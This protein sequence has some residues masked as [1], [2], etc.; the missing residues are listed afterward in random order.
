MSELEEHV[1]DQ[2]PMKHVNDSMDV[3]PLLER[4][5]MPGSTFQM[6][7]RGLFYNN[8]ELHDSVELGEVHVHPMSAY[9]E[10]LMRTPDALFSGEAVNKVF[11]RCIPEVIKPKDLLAKDVDFLLVCLR[12]VTYGETMEI[13]YKHDCEGA[14]SNSYVMNITDSLQNTKKIDPTTV[15][16]T[17]TVK[18]DNGQIVKLH[19][20]KFQDVIKMYQ[21]AKPGD[22]RTPEE[23][24]EMTV[25]IIKSVIFSV[26]GITDENKIKEWIKKIPSSWLKH[27]SKT[28][29]D[30]SDFGP[31]FT[32]HAKC[33]DCDADI[34]IESPINPISFFI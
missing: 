5:E 13:S 23:E 20:S 14:K 32:F 3:N 7:S 2:Q 22:D 10:I 21:E 16:S 4:V 8:G 12:Q 29:E 30:A 34:E 11:Q 25:F 28:I 33:K 19:P 17:Y 27:L 18:L 1:Q 6:P 31:S 26:D 15:G 9:D 24:L